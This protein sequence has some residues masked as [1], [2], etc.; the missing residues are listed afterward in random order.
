MKSFVEEAYTVSLDFFLALH[1]WFYLRG[2]VLL[3]C[4]NP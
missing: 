1:F 4:S 2:S 3:R